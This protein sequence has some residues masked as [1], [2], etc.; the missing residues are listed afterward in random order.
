MVVYPGC[1]PETLVL[2]EVLHGGRCRAIVIE[3]F[4]LL[5]GAYKGALKAEITRV[6]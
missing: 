6:Q 4:R 3:L 1:L 5:S 2:R